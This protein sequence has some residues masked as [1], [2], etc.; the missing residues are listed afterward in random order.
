[1]PS[2][3]MDSNPNLNPNNNNEDFTKLPLNDKLSH[4][5]WKARSLGYQEL[6][7]LTLKLINGSAKFDSLPDN[8]SKFLTDPFAT[9]DII[10]DSNV[11]A[12]EKGII[13]FESIINLLIFQINSNYLKNIN[14]SSLY[15]LWIPSLIDKSLSSTRQVTK[16]HALNSLILLCSIDTSIEKVL[17]IFL[18]YFIEKGK[19]LPKI[20]LALLFG[21]T[22]IIDSFGFINMKNFLNSNILT[23]LLN[24]L[25]NLSNHA[26]VNIRN[27]TVNLISIIFEN[28]V[29]I[30]NSDFNNTKLILIELLMVNLKPIQQRDINKKFD[31]IE[32]NF[33]NE[34]KV[35][36]QYQKL[37]IQ[38]ENNMKLKQS[39]QSSSS[40]SASLLD[41][42]GDI[43][44]DND[45]NTN[46][47]T[48]NNH[49]DQDPFDLLPVSKF[50]QDLPENFNSNIVSDKWKDRVDALQSLY[51]FLINPKNKIKKLTNNG[52][53]Y[54]AL[55]DTLSSI[56]EKD[57]NLQC[58]TLANQIITFVIEKIN[59][60]TLPLQDKYRDIFL[61]LYQPILTRTK[62]KKPT[63]IDA[64]KNNLHLI[65]KYF[66]PLS[67][68]TN[69]DF[70]QILIDNLNL[71]KNPNNKFELLSLLNEIL[72]N[73]FI[74]V[75]IAKKHVLKFLNN[76]TKEEF[77]KM[78]LKLCNESLPKIRDEGFHC[79][80]NLM[81]ILGN[82]ELT[83]VLESL[84]NIKKK[85]IMNYFEN[86][87]VD[88]TFQESTNDTSTSLPLKRG[89]SS[90]LK[91]STIN[92]PINSIGN[93]IHKNQ[94]LTSTT[95]NQSNS[96][97]I[98]LD[99]KRDSLSSFN[100]NSNLT[101]SKITSP[102][103]HQLSSMTNTSNSLNTSRSNNSMSNNNPKLLDAMKKYDADIKRI[104]QQNNELK[105]ELLITN[106]NIIKENNVLKNDIKTIEI[107]LQE[108]KNEFNL[109]KSILNEK[110]NQIAIK[111]SE[112]DKLQ[113]DNISLEQEN[114]RLKTNNSNQ[115][116]RRIRNNSITSDDLPPR[117]NSLHLSS[118]MNITS[119][120]APSEVGLIKA[121]EIQ[122]N[123]S[124]ATSIN[125][126]PS[127]APLLD[128]IE[129]FPSTFSMSLDSPN[130]DGVVTRQ[131]LQRAAKVTSQLKERITR[132]KARQQQ[133]RIIK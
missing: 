30:N 37:Q 41:N 34:Q 13:S 29:K 64:L 46:N 97:N 110:E 86:I 79:I 36:F 4:K 62:E 113:N 57:V 67:N 88:K 10:T 121:P 59:P 66:N 101:N 5:N 118:E 74:N 39:N 26:D 126:Q 19:I 81:Y 76:N 49:S 56:I 78:I 22:N 133:D 21:I 132:I 52:E 99:S 12:L 129:S 9:N 128:N 71:S 18:Q 24:P 35:L 131:S 1:M 68:I 106:K 65:I 14:L 117:V 96:L 28:L 93:S 44:M 7:T 73:N 104:I 50:L 11:I 54:Y 114:K 25:V 107:K 127:S 70:L 112:I 20:L 100:K 122:R 89:P 125:T 108:Q 123:Q 55:F 77:F 42:D 98:G 95:N 45:I 124:R 32:S 92:K 23:D 60:K 27:S 75:S 105:N 15:E 53:N 130:E 119:S 43:I 85:K 87:Q 90:P 120:Q 84:D 109:F 61:I 83:D 72:K 111:N 31:T 115:Y 80:A 2:F 17:L 69:F 63:V 33:N 3:N 38:K 94:Q 82:L 47:R 116:E 6:N 8:I 16:K 40:T 103:R 91:K 51:D 102:T 58:V 48:I